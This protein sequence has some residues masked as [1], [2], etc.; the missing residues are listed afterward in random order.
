MAAPTLPLAVVGAHL[1]GMPLH[2]QIVERGCRLL[3]A[4]RTA[5]HYRLHA[6]PGT[7]PPKPGLARV[8][9]G[10]AA[11]EVE[12][13]EMPLAQVGSF[14]ALIPPPLGLGSIELAEPLG[15]W[16]RWVKGF[17]CEPHALAGAP[18]V[19]AFGGWR[20]YLRDGVR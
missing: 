8:A 16:G 12:V 4:T 20:T 14:L 1:S 15:A 19:S 10:G 6:L 13:Y 11:I 7:V 17:V 2:G 3:A 5:P 9:E 18:D